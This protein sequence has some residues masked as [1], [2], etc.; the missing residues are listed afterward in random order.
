VIDQDTCTGCKYCVESCPF[1][2]PHFDHR[3]GTVKKCS[4]CVDRVANSLEPACAKICPSGAISFGER[5]RILQVAKERQQAL[6]KENPGSVPRIYGEKELGGLGVM[7]L[8]PEKASTYGLIESPGLPMGGIV[9]K[10]FAGT[11]PVAG[12]LYG[13]WRYFRGDKSAES[14]EGG[15]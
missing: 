1:G 2:T 4:M 3:S 15:E 5:E 14:K 12:I 6:G 10:W 11:V 7:Y 13:I 8:L 9:F